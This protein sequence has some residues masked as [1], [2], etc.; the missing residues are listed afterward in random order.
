MVK[1]AFAIA[2][3]AGTTVA[4]AQDGTGFWGGVDAGPAFLERT[5]SQTGSSRDTEFALAFRG[6]YAWHPRLLL[7]LELGG[8]TLEEGDLWDPRQGEGIQTFYAIAHYYPGAGSKFFLRAGF[9]HVQYWNNR[10]G[11]TDAS[12]SGYVLG[13][14]YELARWGSW[15]FEPVIDFSGGKFDGA[16]SPPGVVQDQRY[17]ALTFRLGI[18]YR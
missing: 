9:G 17:E 6:G 15:R 16:T 7:G 1:W 3:T 2:M 14:G 11:E 10:P 13:A 5:Y 8:F 12:D 4:M 18:T